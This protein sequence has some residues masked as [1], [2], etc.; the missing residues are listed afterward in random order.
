MNTWFLS[1]TKSGDL[2]LTIKAALLGI[3]PVLVSFARMQGL[4]IAESDVVEL[5]NQIFALLS[6]I[7]I[8]YGLIRKLFN[9]FS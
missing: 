7:G 8:V 3:V 4:D 1:S 9:R 5:V 6:V 2:S